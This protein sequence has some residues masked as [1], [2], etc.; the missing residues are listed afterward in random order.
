MTP[1]NYDFYVIKQLMG[2][3]IY[4]LTCDT[5]VQLTIRGSVQKHGASLASQ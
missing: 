4:G 2:H 3:K 5:I 1:T